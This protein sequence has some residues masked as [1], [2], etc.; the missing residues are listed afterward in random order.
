MPFENVWMIQ[1]S[2]TIIPANFFTSRS[3]PTCFDFLPITSGRLLLYHP[4]IV[5]QVKPAICHHLHH[6][7]RL[8]HHPLLLHNQRHHHHI[9]IHQHVLLIHF[10]QSCRLFQLGINPTYL[11]V[12]FWHWV[13]HSHK[14]E[15]ICLK[16]KIYLSTS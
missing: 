8:H 12:F 10:E 9:F 16:C 5:I 6:H 15:Y 4:M 13:Q 11:S 1:Y 3:K 7:H 2:N 14:V